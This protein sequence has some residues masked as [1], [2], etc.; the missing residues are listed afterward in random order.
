MAV[1]CYRHTNGRETRLA[2]SFRA[3]APN[4]ALPCGVGQHTFSSHR[5]HGTLK[6]QNTRRPR[7]PSRGPPVEAPELARENNPHI[8]SERIGATRL[9]NML[10]TPTAP[11]HAPTAW[12]RESAPRKSCRSVLDRCVR[13]DRDHRLRNPQRT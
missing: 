3:A 7:R 11:E 6:S 5:P 12:D 1:R 2:L 8:G 9:K 10:W 4:A 13:V